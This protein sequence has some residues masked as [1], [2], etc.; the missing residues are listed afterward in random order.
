[1]PRKS[2]GGSWLFSLGEGE[3]SPP[4]AR[5]STIQSRKC[6]THNEPP[7]KRAAVVLLGELL[8]RE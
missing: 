8:E 4:F 6:G 5:Y 7:D 3:Q 1:M 2:A